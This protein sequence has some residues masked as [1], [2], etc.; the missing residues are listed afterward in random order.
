MLDSGRQVD[1]KARF[2]HCLKI[3]WA[4]VNT[5]LLIVKLSGDK[6]LTISYIKLDQQTQPKIS[7][8]TTHIKQIRPSFREIHTRNLGYR[9]PYLRLQLCCGSTGG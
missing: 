2:T 9:F 3:E 6:L 5:P 1:E 8:P 7:N 4:V